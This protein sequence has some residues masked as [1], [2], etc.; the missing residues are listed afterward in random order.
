MA[1]VDPTY[2]L[3]PV[4]S[5]L[6]AGLL[7]LVLFTGVIRRSMNFAVGSLCFWLF[8]ENIGYTINQVIWSD[9]ATVRLYVYCDICGYKHLG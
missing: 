6:S 8:F 2:P 1:A 3:L 9:N 7:L 5:C 4:A